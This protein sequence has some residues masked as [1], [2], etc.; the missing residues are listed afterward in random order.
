MRIRQINISTRLTLAFSIIIGLSILIGIV[1]LNNIYKATQAT[2]DI[3]MHPFKVGNAVR[4]INANIIAIH[5]SMKDIALAET[6]LEVNRAEYLVNKYEE[7]VYNLFD[8]VFENFLGDKK[9]INAAYNSFSEWK[10]IREEVIQLW[11]SGNIIDA[12]AITKKK[13]AVHVEKVLTDVDVMI[14]FANNKANEFYVETKERED[15]ASRAM[16]ILLLAVILVSVV[17]IIVVSRSLVR[18]IKDLNLIAK[19]IQSG[20]LSV[21]HQINSKDELSKLALAFNSMTD[22]LESRGKV[23]KGLS[24]ISKEL[25]GKEN[26]LD[27]AHSL[28]AKIMELTNSQMATFY[29]LNKHSKSFEPLDS[30]GANVELLKIF[31]AT[32]PEGDF[33]NVIKNKEVYLVKDISKDTIFTYNS[34]IGGIIPKEVFSIPIL[35]NDDVVAIIS[36][37]NINGFSWESKNIL[38]QANQL[39]NASYATLIANQETLEYSHKLEAINQELEMQSEELQEQSEELQQQAN[40][41]KSSSDEL[42]EQN[43]ELEMQRRQVEEANRLK[44]E[45]LSNMSHELRTP[46]NSINALSKVLLMQTTNRLEDDETNYLKIIER[47]GKRLLTL[48]NDILDLSKVEAGKME[49]Y[50]KPFLLNSALSLMTENLQSLAVDK[51]L[52]LN[53]N[54]SEE[55]EIESDESRLH[56]VIT[57]VVGNAIKFTEKGKVDIV[58]ETRNGLAIIKITDTGIGIDKDVLPFIFHEF[59]QGDGTTSRL[60]EGTGLGLAIAKKIILALNGKISVESEKGLGSVFTIEIPL[61]WN[62]IN[63]VSDI[64]NIIPKPFQETKRTTLVVDDEQHRENEISNQNTSNGKKNVLIIEDNKLAIIQVK[65]ILENEG[66]NVSCASNGKEALEIVKTTIPDGIILDLMMP[67]MDGFEVLEKIRGSKQTQD[68]PVLILTAKNLTKNDL[69]RLSSN[70]IQQLIQKGDID[71]KELVAKVNLILTIKPEVKI[72]AKAPE[73]IQIKTPES[74]SFKKSRK[75][76]VLVIEDNPDNRITAR[77]IL[78]NRYDVIEAEDGK[79]GVQMAFEEMPDIILLDISLP[80]KDGLEVLQ[81]IRENELTK[82]FPVIALTAKAMK[83]DREKIIRA[84]CDEYV[85]KPIDD[86]DLLDKIDQLL[87]N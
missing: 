12:T 54:V 85:S 18:P 50:P 1:S 8:V 25:H 70:N 53:L 42:H 46:L 69:N 66:L 33:G 24:E 40:E 19:K 59:R 58:C 79:L 13:G 21:R 20:D 61:E 57:N 87:N 27:F 11:H 30:I 49:I 26:S 32:N 34:T 73:T 15:K 60:Y 55:I 77:A 28:L 10:P 63:K 72:P 29:V 16:L 71:I 2:H 35:V 5:R 48:I 37:A 67:E 4:D 52:A 76:K 75:P 65:K 17:I 31:D 38:L 43:L 44:S 22:S 39:I 86:F 83:S 64:G 78:G 7:E 47:N 74:L 3:H 23:L 6:V 81:E 51:G 14:K 80:E 84:G 45:F 62:G 56:Q 36:Y 9:D 41:L 82:D 68:I